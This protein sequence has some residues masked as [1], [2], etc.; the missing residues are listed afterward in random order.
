MSDPSPLEP[1]YLILGSDRP[2]VRRAVTRLRQRVIG[3]SGSDLNISIFDV[4]SG[5]PEEVLQA[6]LDACEMPGFALGTRLL[7]V[8]NAHRLQAKQRRRLSAC[9]AD[10][11]P[12]TCLA[13]EAP[14][15]AKDD[16]LYKAIARVGMVLCYDLPRK[17]EMA[18]WVQGRARAR[19][20]PLSAPVAKHLLNVC[21]DDPQHAE[22]L[23][24]EIEKLALYCR[25]EAA[26]VQDVDEVCTPD[27]EARIFD[28]LDAVGHRDRA[29]AFRLLETI[30]ASGDPGDDV[31]RVLY[32][33]LR[34]VRLIDA[35]VRLEHTDAQQAARELSDAIGGSVHVFTARKVLEQRSRYDRNRLDCA[36]KALAAAEVGM[37]GRAPA[38]LESGSGVNHSDRLVLELALG[39]ILA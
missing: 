28:L 19:R 25:G 15:L 1:A 38:T 3:E 23:D 30:F 22:R 11:L 32:M 29:R 31:G 37:R 16:P 26:T 13:V 17:Y 9:A 6:V 2:K 8:Q 10:L 18:T 34:H 24:R 7:L 12:G 27:D 36:L 4:E 33:L 5:R 21:G 20:L 39:Q 14:K 35:A